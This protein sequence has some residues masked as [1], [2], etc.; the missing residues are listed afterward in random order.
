MSMILKNT[1]KKY[2]LKK[3]ARGVH[4]NGMYIP[5]HDLLLQPTYHALVDNL[6][7]RGGGAVMLPTYQHSIDKLVAP[8]T[9][10]QHQLILLN[11][12]TTQNLTIRGQVIG[13][14]EGDYKTVCFVQ[15]N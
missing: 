13:E 5:P 4:S 11:C 7:S 6:Y 2:Q 15:S 14:G 1:T 12:N 9:M 8:Q 10:S 3:L